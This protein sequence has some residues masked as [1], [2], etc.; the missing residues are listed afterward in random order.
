[1]VSKA[2]VEFYQKFGSPYP[3]VGSSAE[4]APRCEFPIKAGHAVPRVVVAEY[5][6]WAP[7]RGLPLDISP[8]AKEQAVLDLRPPLPTWYQP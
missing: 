5:D 4:P 1:M 7:P 6:E 2:V 8:A 3:I